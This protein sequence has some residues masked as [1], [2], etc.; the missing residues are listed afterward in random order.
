MNKSMLI[1]LVAGVGAATAVVAVAGYQQFAA[2]KFAEVVDV[3]PAIAQEKVAREVCRDEQVVRK[4]PV[5]DEKQVAGTVTG[6]IVGGLLGNQV[7]DGQGQTIATVAGAAAGGYA[8]NRI[9]KRIQD[10]NTVTATEQRCRT[11]YDRRDKQVGYDVTYVYDG[12]TSTVRM[13]RHPGTKLPVRD[14][15]VLLDA[16]VERS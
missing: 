5:R 15:Q 16:D 10:G 8:G 2:P 11:V 3:K 7:G 1:G 13:D 6:A 12:R 4:A 9:Q 14:G